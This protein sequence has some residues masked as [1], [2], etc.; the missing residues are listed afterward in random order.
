MKNNQR[1]FYRI[2]QVQPDAPLDTIKNNY[3][4]LLHK[5]RLH[6]DLGG[7]HQIASSINLAYSTLK[8]PIK[9]AKYD[10]KLL[11][12]YK[13][14]VLSKGHLSFSKATQQEPLNTLLNKEDNKRNF[15]RLLHVQPDA[16]AAIIFSSY[17]MLLKKNDMPVD[18][19]YEAYSILSNT[20][21]RKQYDQLLKEGKHIDAAALKTFCFE[22]KNKNNQSKKQNIKMK[23][24]YAKHNAYKSSP[25]H[26]LITH[27]CKFC[28]TPQNLN[29]IEYVDA[30]CTECSS[31][32]YS[33]RSIFSRSKRF[34][35]RIELSST[36]SFYTSWP[37]HQSVAKLT[38][39]SPKGLCFMTNKT[40]NKGQII[41]IDTDQFHTIG[42]VKYQNHKNSSNIVGIEFI[43]IQFH[44]SLGTFVSA[45][46]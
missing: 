27:Y 7:T 26:P 37:S 39:L 2:L 16:P 43:T 44:T 3:R 21:K 12:Q 4:T 1:N 18:L 19:I 33:P 14:E 25:Y 24:N 17:Q 29:A 6:P 20:Q 15:Y 9:R 32:L 42:Q 13:I 45:T 11:N 30:L 8:N 22:K 35:S 38:D 28:K 36:I 10:R 31:P 41:K 40:F 5:L 23:V 46:V 34:F